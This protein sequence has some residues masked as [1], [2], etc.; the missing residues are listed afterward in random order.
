M[1]ILHF[2]AQNFRTG[3]R[4]RKPADVVPCPPG[5]RGVLVHE[6]EDCTACGT[7]VYVCS[8]GAIDIERETEG[9]HWRYDAGRCTYCGRCAEY[10]PTDALGFENRSG[11]MAQKRERQWT[12]DW[13]AYRKCE[14]CGEPMLP[15]PV[16]TALRLHH[17]AADAQGTADLF[18]YCEKCR[19]RLTGQRFKDAL[20]GS[21]SASPSEKEK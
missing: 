13:I 21:G 19:A 15:M 1:G 2:L 6:P 11:T 20:T 12:D 5:F 10:C 17:N 8:P 18:R 7:C 9:V 14:R 4:T 16:E 3:S